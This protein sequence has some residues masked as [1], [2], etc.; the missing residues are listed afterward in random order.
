M[1]GVLSWAFVK[2]VPR[3][4]FGRYGGDQRTMLSASLSFPRGSDPASLD[5]AIRELE[6]IVLRGYPEVEQVT[7]QSV[8]TNARMSVLFTRGGQYSG[9]PQA[10][11]EDLTQRAVFI[12]GAS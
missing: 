3:F 7:A 1:L 4:A 9:R 2:K 5:W 8:G 12:G 10:L 11:E 6:A